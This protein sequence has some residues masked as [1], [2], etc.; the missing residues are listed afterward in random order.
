MILKS[1][2]NRQVLLRR[3][4]IND[5]DDLFDYLQNLSAETKN[6]FGPH[7][8]DKQSIIDF[9]T[10]GDLN[11]G[12]IACDIVTNQIVAYFIIKTGYLEHDAVRLQSCGIVPDNKTDCT[13][14]PSVADSWQSCGIGGQLFRFILTDLKTTEISRIILWGGVQTDNIKAVNFYKKNKFKILG[15]FTHNGEN[16]DMYYDII[17]TNIVTH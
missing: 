9:Y 16:Y 7:K 6:R 11:S 15:K 17:K 4:N 1:K 12:Y 13:F 10:P 2:N 5:L 3:L 14:A 8:S